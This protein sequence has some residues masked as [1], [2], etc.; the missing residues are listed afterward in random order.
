MNESLYNGRL[1]GFCPRGPK[2][3]VKFTFVKTNN[4]KVLEFSQKIETKKI[5][6]NW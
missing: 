3:F 5:E 1:D 2:I 4:S 6:G